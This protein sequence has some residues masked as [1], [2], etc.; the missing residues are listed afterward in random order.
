MSSFRN[1]T[2][3][4]NWLKRVLLVCLLIEV[5]GTVLGVQ[6]L[7]LISNL[8]LGNFAS[9]QAMLI[10]VRANDL[11]VRIWGGLQMTATLV[12]IILFLMW[13]YR[14][15]FNA[16]QLGAK[17]MRFTPAWAVGWTFIPILNLWR[18]YQVISEIWRASKNP[19]A[20]EDQSESA[21]LPCWW[22]LCIISMVFGRASLRLSLDAVDLDKLTTATQVLIAGNCVDILNSLVALT[23]IKAIYKMQ[24]S[25]ALLR[26]DSTMY[27]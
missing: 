4:T 25:Q 18:P 22:G 6:R 26:K 27:V 16:C 8:K 14:S 1:P 3:L 24:I 9:A 2:R 13:I 19:T 12:S 10:D 21:L 23:L 17:N 5:A 11:H 7:N 20:W 15:N